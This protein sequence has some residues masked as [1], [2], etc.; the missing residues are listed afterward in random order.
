[1]TPQEQLDAEIERL[2]GRAAANFITFEAFTQAIK[3]ALNTHVI[4]EEENIDPTYRY[5]ETYIRNGL[6]KEQRRV[7]FGSDR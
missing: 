5:T 1:M 4:G 6:R 2:Y 7:L 3:E